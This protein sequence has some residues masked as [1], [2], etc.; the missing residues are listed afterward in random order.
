MPPKLTPQVPGEPSKSTVDQAD[1]TAADTV[2]AADPAPAADE[3]V[4]VPKAQLDSIL[5]RLEAV[6]SKPAATPSRVAQETNLPDQKDV[7]PDKIKTP[8]LT[9]QGWV[10]PNAFG[11]NPAAK[12]L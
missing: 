11:S 9:K 4:A 8:V 6:E 7:N 12:A 3:M 10:V 2:A 1:Q 5:A